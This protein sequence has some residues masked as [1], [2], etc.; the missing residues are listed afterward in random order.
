M[1]FLLHLIGL[2]ISESPPSV[3]NIKENTESPL[4]PQPKNP[5]PERNS[6]TQS[7]S[8]TSESQT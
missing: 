4:I 5:T 3:D 7:L 6:P 2:F 1:W 8:N